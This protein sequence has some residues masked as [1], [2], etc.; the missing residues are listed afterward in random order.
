M[1]AE[2]AE[3][4]QRKSRAPGIVFGL[5]LFIYALAHARVGMTATAYSNQAFVWLGTIGW[6]FA[7][8]AFIKA[9]YGLWG[10]PFLTRRWRLVAAFGAAASLILILGSAQWRWWPM[11]VI[12]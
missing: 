5:F 7:T 8:A 11:M 3:V 10:F 4:T 9:A 12:D 2:G 1:S 6:L